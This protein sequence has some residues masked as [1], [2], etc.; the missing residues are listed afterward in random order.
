MET[1]K[2]THSSPSASHKQPTMASFVSD[3][4]QYSAT[5]PSRQTINNAL[6][7]FIAGD[8]L[9]VS[10]VESS[11]FKSLVQTL[12]PRYTLPSR[13]HFTSTLLHQKTQEVNT[14]VKS[15]LQQAKSVCLTIDLWSSRQMRGFIG[16]TGHYILDWTMKSVMLACSRFRGRH[17]AENISQQVDETLAC[18]DIAEKVTN[19]VTDNA[20]NMIKAFSLPGFETEDT[21]KDFDEDCEMDEAEPQD[22]TD[23]SVTTEHVPCFA[24]T[25]QLVIKDGM[26]QAGPINSVL[27]KAA[28]IVSHVRRSTHATEILE[29]DTKLQAANT[30]RWNSQLAMIRSLLRAPEEKLQQLD[31]PQL[32]KYDRNILG[33]LSEILSPFETATHLLQGQNCVTA[34]LVVPCVRGLKAQLQQM[35][36]KFKCKLVTALQA[37]FTKRM[38]IYEDMETFVMATALDPRFKLKWANGQEL[39]SLSSNLI[40]KATTA[41]DTP[42]AASSESSPASSASPPAKKTKMDAD[43]LDLFLEPKPTVCLTDASPSSIQVEVQEYLEQPVIQRSKDPLAFWSTQD[44]KFPHLAVL[45]PK[46]LALPASSAPVERLFSIS[47]KIFRPARCRLSD[48]VFE[49]LMFLRCNGHLM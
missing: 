1:Q 31:C 49:Q 34:S 46:F 14:A 39:D 12:D 47:G 33:E 26:K 36:G 42:S 24:H 18:F 41:S 30:T 21:D 15:Q 16:I 7:M 43:F 6:V 17:T 13:R 23:D 19:I 8:L 45:A 5:D 20:S 11:N 3:S 32:T 40:S 28:N 9:P 2:P 37:S 48:A 35:A 4:K 38:A 10:L 27:S 22:I 29:G 25:L 44:T